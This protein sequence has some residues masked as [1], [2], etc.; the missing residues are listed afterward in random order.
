MDEASH[1]TTLHWNC[2]GIPED[3]STCWKRLEKMMIVMT[4]T[5]G[6]VEYAV[7]FSSGTLWHIFLVFELNIYYYH[8]LCLS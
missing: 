8:W 3:L 5:T 1:R 2:V 6:R 7:V 4:A